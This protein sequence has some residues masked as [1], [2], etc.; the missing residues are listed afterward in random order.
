M[1]QYR[2]NEQECRQWANDPIHNPKTGYKIDPSAPSGVYQQLLKQCTELGI[3]PNPERFEN[4]LR[5]AKS[6]RMVLPVVVEPARIWKNLSREEVINLAGRVLAEDSDAQRVAAELNLSYEDSKKQ[7]DGLFEKLKRDGSMMGDDALTIAA[8]FLSRFCRCVQ[9]VKGDIS[10]IVAELDS[11]NISGA[12]KKELQK[13]LGT[14]Y[15]K[16]Y[17]SCQKSIYNSRGLKGVATRGQN[18][19]KCDDKLA[20]AQ[21]TIK[22]T[23][24]RSTSK[25]T[26]V[27]VD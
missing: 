22:G 8:D 6:S 4:P 11:P 24:K 10:G 17:G 5:P 25:K 26:K 15:S 3:Q 19:V 27:K 2:F 7:V 12:R 1:V 14:K 13:Q 21:N 16:A 20:Q 9:S 23:A 18:K